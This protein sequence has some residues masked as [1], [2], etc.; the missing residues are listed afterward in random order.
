MPSLDAREQSSSSGTANAV[1]VLMHGVGSAGERMMGLASALGESFPNAHFYA[2]NGPVP[3]VA[4]SDP[5]NPGTGTEPEPGRYQWYVRTS[6]QTR[7]DG[8]YAVAEPVNAF[9]GECL[10]AHGLDESRCVV[11]GF[12]MGAITALNVVPRRGTPIGAFVAHSGYLFSPDSLATR[13]RQKERFHAEAAN[14]TPACLIHG[15]QD[16]TLPWQTMHVRRPLRMRRLGYLRNCTCWA[17][18]A[19]PWTTGVFPSLR[20]SST[21]TST[22]TRRWTWKWPTVRFQGCANSLV[23]RAQG[24]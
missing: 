19:T 17:A 5:K 23:P 11:I 2:P 13:T 3:Y 12:S 21:G 24:R 7:Q 10:A 22:Q 1:M 14:K 4:S 20:H 15:L 16:T 8:L 6:E 9:I 18:W